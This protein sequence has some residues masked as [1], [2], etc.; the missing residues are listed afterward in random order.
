[1]DARALLA[2]ELP[3]RAV[4][5]HAGIDRHWGAEA[6]GRENP[7]LA[8]DAVE[9]LVAEGAAIVGIDS[10]NIDD[11][12]DLTR[13]SAFR[14]ARGRDPDLRAPDEPRRRS[15]QRRLVQRDAR[16]GP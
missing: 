3:E 1:M 15:C 11:P 2:Y 12:G 8:L 13:P 9:L 16:A 7:F 10:L 6:C 14:A 5:V 4:L